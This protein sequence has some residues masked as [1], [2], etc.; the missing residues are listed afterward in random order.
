[1]N[2]YLIY[3][4]AFFLIA[5]SPSCSE[6]K[7][8]E[9]KDALTADV[10]IYGGTSAAVT[11]A[12]QVTKSGKTVLVVS[13]DKH[14]GGLSAGG[15]GFTDTGNKSVIGG[16]AR[17]FYHRL[18]QHYDKPEAWK[19]QKKDEYGNKGQ[20]T[21]AMDGAERTMWIFEPHAAEQV[22]EDFVK[23]NNIKIYRDEWLDRD[24]GVEKKDGKIVSIKTL[25]GKTFAGKMFI[26]ATYEGDLMAAAGVKYHVGRE[27]NSVYNEKWNG[28][29]AGVFQHGHYFKKNISP[30][31]VEGDPKSGLLPYI[32]DEPIAEN[33][34][35]DKKIQAYCFRMCLSSNPDNRIPFEKPEGYD[36]GNYELLAR[37]YKAGW[38]ET[39]DKYDPIPNK[40]TDTNNHGPFSTDFIGENYDYPEATYERR[41][42]IIKAHEVYQKGLMYFLTNDPRVPADVRKEMSKWGLPKDEFKDNGGWPHQ[43]YV[44]EARRMISATVMNENHTMG[45][46]PVE[47]PVGMGS[48]ALDS[49]N[50]QRYVK[51]DGYVQNEGDIGVHPKSPYSISYAS[52]VPKKE[53]CE[54]LFVP[55]C[56]SSSHIAYGSIRMEPVF[57]ILGQS[58]AAAAVQ[59]IDTKVAVQD[60]DYAKLKEQLLKDKQ[61]LE[62]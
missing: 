42:A 62:L 25:S 29:Q 37:V 20:G 41:K 23:E 58:A 31:K 36:V 59:A 24:K 14:L 45:I 26:D 53:E 61:K 52:I 4:I 50:A 11:A 60:V 30:Y 40:K 9:A 6:K 7:N 38:D 15:L 48:Y 39:F 28:V 43:I 33:G 51:K 32:S 27:A 54:N 34:S 13:P 17:E 35:G 49:H 10:I 22:F 8:E 16:L 2:K 44:R 19:W 21:P 57:M 47:Q 12:V 46:T 18:Y 3:L 5:A 55:V 1:M 56:L